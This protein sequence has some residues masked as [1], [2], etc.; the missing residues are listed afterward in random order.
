MLFYAWWDI[1]WYRF[2][3]IWI[4][5]TP[6]SSNWNPYF[7]CHYIIFGG[8]WYVGSLWKLIITLASACLKQSW[9]S[10]W[11]KGSHGP[12]PY[13]DGRFMY[14]CCYELPCTLL[15][16]PILFARDLIIIHVDILLLLWKYWCQVF[17]ICISHDFL[18]IVLLLWPFRNILMLLCVKINT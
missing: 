12:W 15:L 1:W 17:F 2:I 13:L 14:G 16:P 4:Q 11:N 5:P 18:M 8:M 7:T 10:R 3:M 9:C 6:S